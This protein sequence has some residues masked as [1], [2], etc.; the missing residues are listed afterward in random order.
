M[1]KKEDSQLL[2]RILF[3]V[4]DYII[5]A[6]MG[7]GTLSTIYL[8]IDKDWNMPVGMFVGMVLGMLVLL[9]IILLFIPISTAFELFPVGMIISIFVGMV[10]GMMRSMEST[11][12]MSMVFPVIAFSLFAQFIMD[13]YNLRLMGEV[14]VDKWE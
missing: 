12:F 3:K 13:L 6:L 5:A 8:I 1:V 10:V 9:L 14:P 11:A 4:L 7:I 2:L